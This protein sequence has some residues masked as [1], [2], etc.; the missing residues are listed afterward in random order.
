MRIASIGLAMALATPYAHAACSASSGASRSHLV[1]LYTSEGCSSCPPADRWL[2]QLPADA[3]RVALA[4]HVD[5]WDSPS[6]TDRFADPRYTSRQRAMAA[7][8]RSSVVYTPEVALDGREWRNWNRAKTPAPSTAPA[9]A[10]ELHVMPAPELQ[11]SLTATAPAGEAPAAYAAFL[12]VSE[13]GLS[14][15]VKGGENSGATLRHDHVVRAFVGP[16][17]LQQAASTIVLPD[18]LRRDHA[19]VVAF[20]Q[21]VDTGEIASVVELPLA[22][23]ALDEQQR[24]P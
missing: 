3:N 2:A 19:S 22:R 10:L 12:A 13:S 6:W 7:L 21:R 24:L 4:F 8:A 23:C 9:V 16:L 20:V 1:E 18:D 17:P 5:Y 15:T 14:S 11:V